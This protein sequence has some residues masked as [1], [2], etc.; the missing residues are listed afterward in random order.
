MKAVTSQGLGFAAS[1][2]GFLPPVFGTEAQLPTLTLRKKLG[3]KK[4][5]TDG[6]ENNGHDSSV[7]QCLVLNRFC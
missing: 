4:N 1:K 5:D 6:R 7:N 3:K 2:K